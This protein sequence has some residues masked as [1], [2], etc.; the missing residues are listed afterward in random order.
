LVTA[1][2]HPQVLLA[3]ISG[4]RD[5]VSVYDSAASDICR[6]GGRARLIFRP[7]V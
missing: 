5:A 2:L 7:M 1:F 3:N 6:A 4:C